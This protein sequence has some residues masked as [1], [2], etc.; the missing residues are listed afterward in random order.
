MN[1]YLMVRRLRWPLFL[2]LVGVLALLHQ[3]EILRWHLSWP[4]FLIY[5]G[6]FMLAERAALSFD[7]HQSANEF[8]ATSADYSTEHVETTGTEDNISTHESKGV[9]L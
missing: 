3:A 9:Q 5:F 7:Q 1:R 4:I 6:V 2:L 8:D